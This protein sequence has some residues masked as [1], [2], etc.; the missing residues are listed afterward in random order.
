V[1]EDKVFSKIAAS[2]FDIDVVE[3][4]QGCGKLVG[5]PLKECVLQSCWEA[6]W[7]PTT[8]DISS[9]KRSSNKAVGSWLVPHYVSVFCGFVGKLA[10]PPLAV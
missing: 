9:S 10:G 6:G 3:F 8:A 7:A 4:Q 1:V 2:C 5:A